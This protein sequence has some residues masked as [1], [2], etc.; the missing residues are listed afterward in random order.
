MVYCDL[1]PTRAGSSRKN[2]ANSGP[3][4]WGVGEK[5]SGRWSWWRVA[6]RRHVTWQPAVGRAAGS[7]DPRRTSE[8]QERELAVM[9][10]C[11][12]KANLL[13]VLIVGILGLSTNKGR[14]EPEKRSQFLAGRTKRDEKGHPHFLGTG[15]W[16][17]PSNPPVVARF[18][19]GS[20]GKFRPGRKL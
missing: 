15:E 9:K 10:K 3:A 16:V 19:R 18:A 5:K 11:Q 1:E 2:K 12:N 13:E 6:S 20:E 8:W 7:E 17:A 4:A 14:I